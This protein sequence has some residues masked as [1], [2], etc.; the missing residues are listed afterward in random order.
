MGEMNEIVKKFID[1]K[2]NFVLA[3]VIE[4]T[5]STPRKKGAWLI[6]SIDGKAYGTV[7][8]GNLEAL[9]EEICKNT[10]QT[11]ESKLYEFSLTPEEQNGIDMRC[12]GD[13]KVSIEYIDYGKSQ[14]LEDMVTK[15]KAF[16]FGA[17][18]VGKEIAKILKYVEFLTIILDDRPE[19][20]NEARFPDADK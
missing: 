6:M 7:G 20:A 11:K 5:G 3:K 19:F 10:F 2:E 9:V 13:A 1:K 14:N 17:G 16:I 18:H 12:G 4:T 15:P 8:G